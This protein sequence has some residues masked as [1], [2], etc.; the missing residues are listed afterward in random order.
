MKL[1]FLLI[2]SLITLLLVIF[3]N[4]REGYSKGR[5]RKNGKFGKGPYGN[6]IGSRRYH[7]NPYLIPSYPLQYYYYPQS[8][9]TWI[10]GG[11]YGCPLRD[12]CIVNP[13]YYPYF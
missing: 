9:S 5:K 6:P 11:V 13:Y 8:L 3:T 2:L 10:P 7:Y 1:I 4:T 12:G